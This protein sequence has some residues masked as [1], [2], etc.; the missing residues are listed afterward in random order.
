[1]ELAAKILTTPGYGG[2]TVTLVAITCLTAYGLTLWW[3]VRGGKQEEE[4]K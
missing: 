1:M 2:A 4:H 3:I